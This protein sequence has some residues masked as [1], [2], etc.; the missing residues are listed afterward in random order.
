MV[1]LRD[2][3]VQVASKA[4]WRTDGWMKEEEEKDGEGDFVL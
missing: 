4:D 1:L 2:A 3:N